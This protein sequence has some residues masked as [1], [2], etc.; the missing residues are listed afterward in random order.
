[1]TAKTATRRPIRERKDVVRNRAL[2]LQ[3][4]DRLIA[5]RGL[6]VSFHDVAREAGVGIGTVYRHFADKDALL[7]ALVEQRFDAV[8]A[9]LIEAERVEDAVDALRG[10]ILRICELQFSDRATREAIVSDADRHRA[11]VREQLLPILNRIVERARSSGRVRGDFSVTDLPM[12]FLLTGAISHHTGIVRPDLWRR[13]VDTLLDGFVLQ[14]ADRTGTA[15]PAATD[16][17]LDEITA[18][19]R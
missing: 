10:T 7:G 3:A 11:I 8:R 19:R 13:Y 6:E 4:A 17:E 18:G 5:E 2:L 16:A 12:I 15:V 9:V 14:A 1:M